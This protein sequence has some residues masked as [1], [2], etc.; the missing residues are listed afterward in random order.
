MTI[1]EKPEDRSKT[2]GRTWA[3]VVVGSSY[4]IAGVLFIAAIIAVSWYTLGKVPGWVVIAILGS[5]AF[6]PFL[7]ERAK[8]GSE[9]F[10]V[11]DGPMRMT[12]WRIG[13]RVGLTLDGSPISFT[14]RSGVRRSIL[15][16]F[17]PEARTGTGS[18]LAECSQFDQIRDLNTVHQLS[19]SL[20]ATLRED[21]LTMMHVGIE[22]E[23]RSR[24]IVDWALQLIYEGTVPTEITEALGV[25]AI[26][27]P[28]VGLEDTL[29]GVLEHD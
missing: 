5:F 23:R 20:E 28:D 15:V 9:L 6:I 7:T 4:I 11:L 22:V 17:D 10:I 8:E 12:E 13:H 25:E 18:M 2:V 21:R 24:E 26:S 19:K 14:S 1:E 16:D 27:K 3:D 29:E